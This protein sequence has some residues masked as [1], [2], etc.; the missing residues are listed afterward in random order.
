MIQRRNRPRLQLEPLREPF[1]GDLYRYDA[2]QSRVASLVDFAHTARADGLEDFVRAKKIANGE[3]HMG[4]SVQFTR[5][6]LLNRD[7]L[8][9]D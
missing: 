9:R 6:R 4:D 1:V 7:R 5:N 2:V 8:N 3:W